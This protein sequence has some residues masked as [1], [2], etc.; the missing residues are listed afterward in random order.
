[1][2]YFRY[3]SCDDWR[4]HQRQAQEDARYYSHAHQPDRWDNEDCRRA[5]DDE[6]R[7]Q[8]HLRQQ[9]ED[10]EAAQARHERQQQ[11]ARA[12]A[13]RQEEAQYEQY[14]EEQRQLEQQPAEPEPTQ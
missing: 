8:E 4:D 1:M 14:L 11:E 3:P 10:E 2:S 5:Y 12:E 7:H 6:Y 13:Q 9:R